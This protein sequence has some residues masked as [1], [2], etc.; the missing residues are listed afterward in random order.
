MWWA[1]PSEAP[2]RDAAV[3][4]VPSPRGQYNDRAAPPLRRRAALA[5]SSP[6]HA[7]AAGF[8]AAAD[9]VF[10]ATSYWT[11]PCVIRILMTRSPM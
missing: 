2:H 7:A 11:S 6:A 8:T 10:F 4:L 5:P 9:Q 3:P 1:H